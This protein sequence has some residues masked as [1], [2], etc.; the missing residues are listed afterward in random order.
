MAQQEQD[1]TQDVGGDTG[2]ETAYDAP[3]SASYA[4]GDDKLEWAFGYPFALR[5]LGVGSLDAPATLLDY[6]CGPGQVAERV[7]R[8]YGVWVIA[9]DASAEMLA[10]AAAR[11]GHPQ[12][13]Y[14][15]VEGDRLTFLPDARVDAA[16]S[17]F[18]FVVL[19]S[20]EQLRAV[21]DEVWRVLRPGGRFVVLDPH[22]DQVGV[23]FSTFC[24]G[25]PGVA[26]QEGDPERRGCC[27]PT[28][29]GWTWRTT[30]GRPAPTKRFLR[31]PVSSTCVPRH[32]CWRIRTGWPNRMRG[33]TR[34]SVP[35]HHSC[36]FTG[37]D[38]AAGSAAR[39]AYRSGAGRTLSQTALRG[40]TRP[41]AHPG[42]R[43]CRA[44]PQSRG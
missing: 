23:Q 5:A 32:R 4:E 25:E 22:P 24:T 44:G 1:A 27:S 43:R 34:S 37:T 42:R 10:I 26:Y 33:T 20:R 13:Q 36:L 28:V 12:V 39:A 31:R 14:H 7:A 16:M 11:H 8:T 17:C 29:N 6:G 38:R 40:P 19:P 2:Q 9:V 41:A 18:V 3:T 21:A 35:A 15:R 30:S